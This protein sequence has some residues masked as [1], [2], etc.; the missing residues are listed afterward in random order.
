MLRRAQREK[1]RASGAMGRVYAVRERGSRTVQLKG[2]GSLRFFDETDGDSDDM[3]VGVGRI[4]STSVGHWHA[5]AEMGVETCAIGREASV[6]SVR[7]SASGGGSTKKAAVG[8]LGKGDG[9][10]RCE[11]LVDR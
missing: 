8:V 9:V 6:I 5:L 3:R 11:G 2:P 10:C 4:C 7:A 1:L